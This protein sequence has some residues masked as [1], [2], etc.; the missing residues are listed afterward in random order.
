MIILEFQKRTNIKLLFLDKIRYLLVTYWCLHMEIMQ[1]TL[2]I[3]LDQICGCC[4]NRNGQN[5]ACAIT[6]SVNPWHTVF[7]NY[8]HRGCHV[9]NLPIGNLSIV[10]QYQCLILMCILHI[11]RKSWLK[12][13]GDEEEEPFTA[14]DKIEK[15]RF[16]LF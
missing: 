12:L 6:R 8:P 16:S 14:I 15:N 10:V 11:Y 1:V 2:F 4:G 7:T 5:I 3:L 13:G 9:A